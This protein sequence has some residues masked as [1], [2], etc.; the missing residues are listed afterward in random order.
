MTATAPALSAQARLIETRR[1][2]TITELR[3]HGSDCCLCGKGPTDGTE[4]RL[5]DPEPGWTQPTMICALCFGPPDESDP[6]C[7]TDLPVVWPV[8]PESNR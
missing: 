6:R 3:R 2:Q 5:F 4:L 7:F 8:M 1:A